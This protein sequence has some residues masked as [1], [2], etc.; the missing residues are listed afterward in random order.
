MSR[1]EI[2]HDLADAFARWRSREPDFELP[3]GGESLRRFHARVERTLAA[4]VR[5]HRGGTI[6]LVTHGGVLDSV[7]RIANRLPMQA[8]RHH[9]L[10]N[11]SLNTISWNGESYSQTGW[12]D[13]AHLDDESDDSAEAPAVPGN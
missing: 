6:V 4:L 10:L 12:A 5:R 2:E 8:A 7:Y 3:G 11:A 1:D 13:V 9:E